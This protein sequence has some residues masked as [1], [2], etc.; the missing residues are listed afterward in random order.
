[1]AMPHNAALRLTLGLLALWLGGCA[2]API[3]LHPAPSAV[4]LD[5]PSGVPLPPESTHWSIDM[6]GNESQAFQV[7]VRPGE[8]FLS[9][10][11]KLEV[12]VDVQRLGASGGAVDAPDVKVYQVL[13]VHYR[14]PAKNE[15]FHLPTRNVGWIP[16]VCYPTHRSVAQ[17]HR[18]DEVTFLFDVHAQ[19]NLP[20][21]RYE[22]RLSFQRFGL[23]GPVNGPVRMDLAVNVLPFSLPTTLPFKTALTWNWQIE[24]YLGRPLTAKERGAYIDFFLDH[25]FTPAYFFAKGP[26][27]TP[28]EVRHIVERGGNVF[29]V[30]QLGR[31]G[32]DVL[33]AQQ[34]ATY[35]GRLKQW[36]QIM[37]DAGAGNDCYALI[38]DEPKADSVAA[39]RANAAWLKSVWPELKIWVASRP[40]PDLMDVVD[41]WDAVTAAS[42]DF[43]AAHSFTADS[44]RLARNAPNQPE[45]WWFYSVEPYA[46]QPNARIDDNL[47]DSRVIGLLSL[48]QGMDGFEYFW[49]T[50]WAGNAA[51]ASIRYPAKAENWDL[52]LAGAG[53]LAYPGD[54][55]LPIPSLRLINL[56]DG[57]QDWAAGR[58]LGEKN[59]P[60]YPPDPRQV[61]ALLA[62]RSAVNGELASRHA[63]TQPAKQPTTK[64]SHERA[65]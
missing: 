1:M 23:G 34:Q 45:Y 7:K 2:A 18:G 53:M 62:W 51:L 48:R 14:G 52:A 13:D 40:V 37:I 8:L 17:D 24:K 11:R 57:M 25:R 39:I 55:G 60:T 10:Q 21:G 47:V 61:A 54:D 49:A 15:T 22:Y 29:Q 41:C 19:P 9:G 65:R 58:M 31:G 30:F 36:R 32:K 4:R 26:Q 3:S 12:Q 50:D 33:T 38:A 44:Y 35:E 59:L 46:P 6:A 63:T 27:F 16:D 20:P 28:A 43:Y 56:R 64:K 5:G 42:T